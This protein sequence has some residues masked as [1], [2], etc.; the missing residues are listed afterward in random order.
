[1]VNIDVSHR[2]LRRDTALDVIQEVRGN[3]RDFQRKIR[4]VLVDSVVLTEYNKSATYIIKD[5]KF[6]MTPNDTFPYYDR[7]KKEKIDLSYY[8]YFKKQ[9]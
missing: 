1:M 5:I 7:E 4:A 9:Y 6:D 3:T 2:V 8:D